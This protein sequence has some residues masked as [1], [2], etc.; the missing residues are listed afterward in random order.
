MKVVNNISYET[1]IVFMSDIKVGLVLSGGGA[2]GMAHVGVLKALIEN[3]ISPNIV[4]GTSIGSLVGGVYSA[5]V[6]LENIEKEA[7][8]ISTKQLFDV[9]LNVQGLLSGKSAI[10]LIKNILGQ[11]YM[12][13]DLKVKYGAVAVDIMAAKEELFT[14]GSLLDAIRASISVPGV[15]IPHK[16]GEKYYVD[17]GILNN[18]PENYALDMGADYVISVNLMYGYKPRAIPKTAIHSVVYTSFIMQNEIT[19]MRPKLSNVR[20]DL[21][22]NGFK[23]HIF[24]KTSAEKL[25][26]I[27]YDETKKQIDKIKKDIAKIKK[28]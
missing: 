18:L 12:I 8:S 1:E 3:G 25:I 13:E 24:N 22:L 15:F 26:K 23:Q 28:P 17:G 11:D 20:I 21:N 19:N 14:S 4:V 2:L 5:G 10:K 16:I 6:P 27:G 7:L 9:N